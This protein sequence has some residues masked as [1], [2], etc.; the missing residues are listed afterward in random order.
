[1]TGTARLL[2]FLAVVGVA[3]AGLVLLRCES[4]VPEVAV[5]GPLWIGREARKVTFSA[6][7]GGAGLR[8]SGLRRV[9][10]TLETGETSRT[11]LSSASEGGLRAWLLGAPAEEGDWSVL[12]SAQGLPDGEA[13][14][15]VRAVDWSW[16]NGF[17]GNVA[18][19]AAPVTIDTRPPRVSVESGLT[20]VQR[21]GSGAV[22]YTVEEPTARDGVRVGDHFFRGAPADEA[23][24][25]RVAVFAV[26]RD[27]SEA[28]EIRV[29]ATD[30]AGNTAARGWATRFQERSFDEVDVRLPDRFFEQTVPALAER[31][32]IPSADPAEAFRTI[33]EEVRAANEARIRE[34]TGSASEPRHWIGPFHQMRNSSV[35]SRFA[36]KRNYLYGG[37]PISEAVHYGYDLAST[38]HAPVTAANAGVVIFADDLGI[39]G[40]CVIVDHGSGITSLYGH[41]SRIDV[42]V[43]DRVEKDQSLGATGATGLAGGDHLHF[44]VLVGGVYVDPLE[45]WDPRWVEQRVEARILGAA[46]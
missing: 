8:R 5:E 1:L 9:E 29:V 7:D 12:L 28:P 30:L 10:V 38:A 35:T 34:I 14:L 18:E 44:A 16:A 20:Y 45:W 32:G 22:A 31:L 24:A 11:L 46:P 4:V 42:A 26:P 41:L 21:A 27:A 13:T 2:V 17:T 36:E 25:R 43:G 33:N 15:R 39:Y 6:R 3:G 37:E 23:G 19:A 40:Q